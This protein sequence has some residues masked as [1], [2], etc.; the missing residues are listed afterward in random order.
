VVTR[1]APL[2]SAREDA[3]PTTAFVERHPVLAYYA[4][5]FAISWGGVLLLVGG[6]GGIPGT[7][8]Q[9]G[10]LTWSVVLVLELGPPTAGLLLTGLVAGRAGHAELLGRLLRWRVGWRWYAV[11]LLTAPLLGAAVLLPLSLAS[12]AYLPGILSAGDKA[13]LLVPAVVAGL[14]G[15]F[16]EELG[17]TGF[18]I[19]RLRRR[20][21]VLATGLFVGALWGVWHYVVTPAWIAGEYAGELPLAHFLTANG[22]LAVVGQLTAYRILMAWV[23]DRTGSLSVTALMHT[24]LIASTLFV[25]APVGM[26]GAVYVTWS[27]ALAVAFWL[28]VAAVAVI[29]PGR[30][31][32]GPEPPEKGEKA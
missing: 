29:D 5:T 15:G 10:S 1:G 32:S 20:H 25:L 11:A 13:A 4:V 27:A 16:G 2:P 12:P 3:A 24:S 18:A 14:L 17:W 6:P 26:T 8:E 23:H 30:L 9:I 28:A 21:G 7:P 22:V 19:P 31:A